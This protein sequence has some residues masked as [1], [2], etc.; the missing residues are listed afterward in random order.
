MTFSRRRRYAFTS[1]SRGVLRLYGRPAWVVLAV[2]LRVGE[3][4]VAAGIK[5]YKVEL[6]CPL[7]REHHMVERDG[8]ETHVAIGCQLCIDFR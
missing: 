8:F 1:A 3:R 5:H 2:T 7:R 4:V 6:F